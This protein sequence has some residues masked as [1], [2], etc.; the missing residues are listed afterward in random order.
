MRSRIADTFYRPENLYVIIELE[1]FYGKYV[2][3]AY[4][5]RIELK[6][7]VVHVG[8]EKLKPVKKIFRMGNWIWYVSK[9][10]TKK[11]VPFIYEAWVHG[12][13]DEF[14]SVYVSELAGAEELPISEIPNE[15]V[16]QE[17]QLF[18]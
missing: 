2:D 7:G 16:N 9:I 12:D 1:S 5:G 6:N 4:L 18:G 14:G 8:Y 11:K 10:I 3:D 15:A 13:F 17:S